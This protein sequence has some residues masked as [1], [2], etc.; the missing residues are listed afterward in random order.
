MTRYATEQR[1]SVDY[2]GHPCRRLQ[3]RVYDLFRRADPQLSECTSTFGGTYVGRNTDTL[4]AVQHRQAPV[5]YEH[6]VLFKQ[7]VITVS[8]NDQGT[9]I[10]GNQSKP[11]D[12]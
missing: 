6:R 4:E 5:V 8:V 7:F 3:P 11:H 9:T 10:A 1:K 2:E 12:V